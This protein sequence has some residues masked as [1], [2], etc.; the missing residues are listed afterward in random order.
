MSYP[1]DK[2]EFRRVINKDLSTGTPGSVL[3]EDDHNKPVDLLERLQDILGYGI[4]MGY[5]TVRAFFDYVKSKADLVDG[6]LDKVG[7]V[8]TDTIDFSAQ[9]SKN[10]SKIL[11]G[12]ISGSSTSKPYLDGTSNDLKIFPYGGAASNRY[13][14]LE[15]GGVFFMNNLEFRMAGTEDFYCLQG[16]VKTDK[17]APVSGAVITLT[18]GLTA[19]SD[20]SVTDSAK[21]VVLKDRTTATNY[22]LYVDNGVLSVEAA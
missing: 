10:Q 20:L 18:G 2:E 17:L 22:R 16:T 6:K 8:L 7:T 11:F 21:G 19:S 5:A 3:D 14:K 1:V 12:P 9:E 13:I 4:K 15:V